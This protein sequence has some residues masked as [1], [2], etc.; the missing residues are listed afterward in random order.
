MFKLYRQ[1]FFK[2]NLATRN[3]KKNIEQTNTF[4]CLKINLNQTLVLIHVMKIGPKIM[5]LFISSRVCVAEIKEIANVGPM[6][7][8]K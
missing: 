8:L 3:I 7:V 2:E 5:T 1:Y 6:M 4:Y